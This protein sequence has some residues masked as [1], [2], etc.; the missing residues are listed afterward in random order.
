MTVE[1]KEYKTYRIEGIGKFY[2]N[3][4]VDIDDKHSRY[5]LS[6]VVKEKRQNGEVESRP[7][8]V[9]VKGGKK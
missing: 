6:K 5:L 2:K 7:V 8:F 3:K 1:L 4:P 9:E